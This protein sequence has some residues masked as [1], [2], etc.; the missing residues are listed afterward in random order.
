MNAGGT[1]LYR[2]A[3]LDLG[4]PF[5]VAELEAFPAPLEV[6]KSARVLGGALQRLGRGP[7]ARRAFD[8]AARAVR[9]IAEGTHDEALRTG[10]LASAAV[11][12]VLERAYA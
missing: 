10:F 3:G 6:W 4:L 5:P 8:T 2:A 9:T 7:E 12:E 1:T 11:R